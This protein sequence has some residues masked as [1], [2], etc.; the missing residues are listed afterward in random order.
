MSFPYH[1]STGQPDQHNNSTGFYGYQPQREEYLDMNMASGHHHGYNPVANENDG[2]V[3]N[4]SN[5]F[6]LDMNGNDNNNGYPHDTNGNNN[7]Y[8]QDLKENVANAGEG[9][10]G[11][12]SVMD[13]LNQLNENDGDGESSAVPHGSSGDGEPPTVPHGSSGEGLPYAPENWPN[14]GDKWSWRVGKKV[15]NN[16]YYSDRFLYLPKSLIGFNTPKQPFGSKPSVE[17][18]IAENF[19]GADINAFFASFTWEIQSTEGPKLI[20]RAVVPISSTIPDPSTQG[21]T[22]GTGTQVNKAPQGRE[23]RKAAIKARASIAAPAYSLVE[24]DGPEING[25]GAYSTSSRKGKR[26]AVV[27]PTSP[28]SRSS[29]RQKKPAVVFSETPQQKAPP[30]SSATPKRKTRQQSGPTTANDNGTVQVQEEE[31]PIDPIEFDKYLSSLDDIISQPTFLEIIEHG[32]NN[33]NGQVDVSGHEF[34]QSRIKLSSLLNMEDFP[35]LFCSKKLPELMNLAS[36]IRKDPSLSAEQLVKLKLVEEIHMY[37]E[38]YLENKEIAKQAENFFASLASNKAKVANLKNEYSGLKEQATQLQTE[39]D[40]SMAAVQEIDEQ[41]AMLRSQRD[42]LT[43][44]IKDKNKKISEMGVSKNSVANSIPKVV[45]EIQLANSK[46]PEW[47]LKKKNAAKREA[48]MMEKF[49]SLRGF[50]L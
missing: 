3:A 34:M 12:A 9:N 32:N 6:P 36:K 46:K 11:F 27:D 38:V 41:I 33:N 50:V 44:S 30:R 16:G 40:Y 42:R 45:Q 2:N 48:E 7:D 26:K 29:G 47:E 39:V 15:K 5:D 20:G 8:G 14:P 22:D 1:H 17:R 21:T 10:V 49:V 31:P 13:I 35:S 28:K 4:T 37:S 23:K 25:D 18:Y 43:T 24:K 19:P